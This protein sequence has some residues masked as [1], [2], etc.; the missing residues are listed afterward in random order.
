MV[1]RW[2]EPTGRTSFF[3][4]FKAIFPATPKFL[5]EKLWTLPE[6]LTTLAIDFN[7]FDCR[8]LSV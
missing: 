7:V 1:T 2:R 4:Q 6:K 8:S 3:S 5:P